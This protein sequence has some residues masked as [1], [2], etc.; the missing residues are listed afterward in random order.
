[1]RERR[2]AVNVTTHLLYARNLK[3]FFALYPQMPY[4]V[5]RRIPILEKLNNLPKITKLK[6]CRIVFVFQNTFTSLFHG[7][8]QANENVI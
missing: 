2:K 6:I 5:N 7:I 8:S 3:I 4:K 1:M